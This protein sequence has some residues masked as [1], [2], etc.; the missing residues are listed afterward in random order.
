MVDLPNHFDVCQVEVKIGSLGIVET[1]VGLLYHYPCWVGVLE[2]S[3][4]L[5]VREERI[6]SLLDDDD[7]DIQPRDLANEQV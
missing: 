2:P 5:G 1:V 3:T 7:L 6:S 4:A